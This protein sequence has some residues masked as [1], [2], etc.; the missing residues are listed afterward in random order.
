[1]SFL[2]LS[3]LQQSADDFHLSLAFQGWYLSCL[4]LGATFGIVS[5]AV[6]HTTLTIWGYIVALL[7]GTV[8]APLSCFL[9]G[10][11]GTG[12]STNSISKM[13]SGAILPGR[14][15]ANLYFSTYSHGERL[16]LAS[17]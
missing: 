14:P 8:I 12:I 4:V 5:I 6:G 2:S 15:L 11:M 16:P 17:R 7:L 9:Y 10:V 1:V 3:Q 13:V